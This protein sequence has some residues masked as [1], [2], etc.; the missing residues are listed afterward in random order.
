MINPDWLKYLV[1]LAETH[2]FHS[3]AERLHITPQALSKAIAALEAHY[4]LRLVE[5]DHRVRG[6]TPAGESLVE[7][8]V[9]LLAQLE[10]TERR[11]AEW[12]H[13]EPQGPIK[14][15]GVDVWNN[16][17]LPDMFAK[18]LKRF[19]Q[20]RPQIFNMLPQEVEQWVTAGEV[21]IGVLL[22]P[23][24]HPGL[25]WKEGL[26]SPYVIAGKPGSEAPWQELGFIVPR[27]FRRQ[28]P[29]SMDGWP[30][31]A[32]PRR[33]VAEVEMLETAIH[34]CEAG[35]GVAFM[36]ELAIRAQLASG[37]LAVVAEAPS[38]YADRLFV[39]WRKGVRLTPAAREMLQAMRAL[40]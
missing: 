34:L 14:I 31:Q 35:V 4:G 8:A 26:H 17:L 13:G 19:P 21:D 16:Y 6:L 24:T 30:E 40:D 9:T 37:T 33:I 32:F 7:E 12:R 36:P 5:R 3:A 25:E 18:L 2:N 10:S 27:F 22:T 15:A 23:P 39:T 28:V 20:I 11:M 29:M 38:A 1:L